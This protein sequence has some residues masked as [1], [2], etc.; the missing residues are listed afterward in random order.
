MFVF[1]AGDG[2]ADPRR[3]ADHDVGLAGVHRAAPGPAVAMSGSPVTTGVP[4]GMPSCTATSSRTPRD[5]RALGHERRQLRGVDTGAGDEVGVV[6]HQVEPAHVG[7]PG[8]G[9][10]RVGR[11]RDAGEA[12]RQV[13]DRLEEPARRGQRCRDGRASGT[14]A[15]RS[16]PC[17]SAPGPRR[18]CGSSGGAPPAS[19]RATGPPKRSFVCRR[20]RVSV[21]M[22]QF[23]TGFAVGVDGHR[24]AHCP[25]AHDDRDLLAVG[26]R[27][28]DA[29]LGSST[30]SCPTTRRRPARARRPG[31]R[32]CGRPA[33]SLHNTVAVERRPGRPSAR[34]C[35]GRSRRRHGR[36]RAGVTDPAGPTASRRAC[37]S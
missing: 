32:S 7:E 28:R 3:R 23:P 30:R 35:R 20:P 12:H 17:R 4:A 8:R 14:G 33:W 2:A 25:V 27:R 6:L 13:V 36:P 21:H 11:R 1:F 5:H 22:T 9:H 18:S 15:V 26:R 24:A 29:R 37:R 10:R 34:W 16:G 19:S 31:T